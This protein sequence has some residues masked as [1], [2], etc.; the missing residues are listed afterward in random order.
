[1]DRIGQL[2]RLLSHARRTLTTPGAHQ[3]V[4]DCHKSLDMLIDRA[5]L[6]CGGLCLFSQIRRHASISVSNH[7]T[8]FAQSVRAV[9]DV[10][11]VD[12]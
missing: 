1:L 10:R 5:H 3:H 12:S 7:S 9:P 2:S 4:S 8:Q 6:F 11:H